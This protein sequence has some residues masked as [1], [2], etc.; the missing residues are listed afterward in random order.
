MILKSQNSNLVENMGMLLKDPSDLETFRN[1]I[2]DKPK[3]RELKLKLQYAKSP[4][5]PRT[6]EKERKTFH[7]T[8]IKWA[9][10]RSF[11]EVSYQRIF[12]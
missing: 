1:V 5:R 8:R 10:T 3:E 4:L 2:V 12:F 9:T 6:E 11:E 7:R